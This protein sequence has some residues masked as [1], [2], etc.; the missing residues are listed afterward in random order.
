MNSLGKNFE[1]KLEAPISD[2]YLEL[3]NFS[4]FFDNLSGIVI[5]LLTYI[6]GVVIFA[7]MTFK[8]DEKTYVFGMLRVLGLPV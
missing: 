2:S 5:C 6:S 1:V 7:L 8:V 4:V 3:S